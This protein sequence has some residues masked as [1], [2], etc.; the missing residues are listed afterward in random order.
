MY[1]FIVHDEAHANGSMHFRVLRTLLTQ[2][3][4]NLM[5]AL[6]DAMEIA[7]LKVMSEA[8]LNSHGIR[9]S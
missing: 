5:P 9:F 8:P 3:L 6:H 1:G 7:L 2:N 4:K